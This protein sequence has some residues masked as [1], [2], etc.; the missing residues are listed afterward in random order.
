MAIVTNQQ[1][2]GLGYFT[3][4]DFIAVNQAMLKQLAARGVRISKI[5]F[6]PH[7]LADGCTCRKPGTRMLERALG[8][9]GFAANR[10]FVVGD[11]DAD[12]A[13]AQALGIPCLRIREQDGSSWESTAAA[14]EA[15]VNQW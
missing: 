9:F 5:Y 2:I 3:M 4:D 15:A 11:S 6:C 7:S 14:I 8:D 10:A 12:T 1:G 13:A